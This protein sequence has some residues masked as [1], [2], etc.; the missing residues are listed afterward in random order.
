MF[1]SPNQTDNPHLFANESERKGGLDGRDL[2][3]N[4]SSVR[5]PRASRE[6]AATAEHY[7][8]GFGAYSIHDLITT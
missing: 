5:L 3:P 6:S 8:G 7:W 2:A 1:E 4:P